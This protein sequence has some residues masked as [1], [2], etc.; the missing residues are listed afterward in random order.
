MDLAKITM[1]TANVVRGVKPDQLGAPTPC[2][3]WDIRTLTN[4]LLQVV[5]ALKLAGHHDVVPG[6]LWERDFGPEDG[7]F[8]E[9]AREAIAAW[10]EPGA[11]EGTIPVGTAEMPAGFVAAMLA[12]DL[13]IHGWDLARASGQEYRVEQDAAEATYRFVAETAEQGRGMGIFG[14]PVP[15][16]EGA[17][18]LDRALALSGRDP[19][20]APP[21]R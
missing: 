4:H 3:D 13:V 20:W 16:A 11:W 7:R 1:E 10:A 17:P 5:T 2:R 8:E 15:V 14:E 12:T 9:T 21:L 18:A 6:E 19:G